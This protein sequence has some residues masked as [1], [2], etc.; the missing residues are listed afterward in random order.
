LEQHILSYGFPLVKHPM[1]SVIN[2]PWGG[3]LEA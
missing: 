2:R 1:S 3:S